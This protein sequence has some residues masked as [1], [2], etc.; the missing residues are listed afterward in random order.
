MRALWELLLSA[1]ESIGGVPSQFIS[2]KKEELRQKQERDARVISDAQQ[3][4]ANGQHM[5]EIRARERGEREGRG[6]G[7]GRGGDFGG[8]A[9]DSG[10]SGR[11]RGG[12]VAVDYERVRH[13][14]RLA[15][16]FT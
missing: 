11:G 12:R 9:R 10:W 7:R 14:N 5:N 6:R 8:R 15:Y 3:R 1:Q 4:A 13:A 16:P 2:E